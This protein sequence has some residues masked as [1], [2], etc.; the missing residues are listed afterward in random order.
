MGL[1]N[2]EP[3]ACPKPHFEYSEFCRWIIHRIL[4]IDF[5]QSNATGYCGFCGNGQPSWL[6]TQPQIWNKRHHPTPT[7]TGSHG[8][9]HQRSDYSA[10]RMLQNRFALTLLI[11]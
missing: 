3:Q 6:I 7:T 1:E 4:R 9:L 5:I 2:D 8:V 11:L 10:Q